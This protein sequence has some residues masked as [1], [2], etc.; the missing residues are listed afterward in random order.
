M[1]DKN[2]LTPYLIYLKFQEKVSKSDIS[3][4]VKRLK[5]VSFLF[6]GLIYFSC[7]GLF[8]F[9][10]KL[11]VSNNFV[12]VFLV[13]GVTLAITLHFNIIAWKNS[14]LNCHQGNALCALN[15]VLSESNFSLSKESL[16]YF[17]NGQWNLKKIHNKGFK[18]SGTNARDSLY[19][20]LTAFAGPFFTFILSDSAKT[21]VL[22]FVSSPNFLLAIVCLLVFIYLFIVFPAI[23]L[24]QMKFDK[25]LFFIALM[26]YSFN[27]SLL[28]A[29]S[30]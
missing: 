1:D 12:L 13:G 8:N 15:A 3:N 19:I 28:R 23:L 17:Y 29:K 9:Y 24:K 20:L 6:G 16:S 18:P 2:I 21:L 4:D 22:N 10:S 5:F 7:F 11:G 25:Q 26:C 14:L 30:K 27:K